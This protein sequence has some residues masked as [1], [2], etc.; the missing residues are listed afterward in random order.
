MGYEFNPCQC[1]LGLMTHFYEKR[2]EKMQNDGRC[3]N[4]LSG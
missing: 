1:P 4:A 2:Y 3:V